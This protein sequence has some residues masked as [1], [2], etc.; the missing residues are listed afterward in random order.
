MIVSPGTDLTCPRCNALLESET[1][2]GGGTI[3]QSPE[4][5]WDARGYLRVYVPG[6]NESNPPKQPSS[7][8]EQAIGNGRWLLELKC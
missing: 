4:R 1:I 2:A 6:A 5:R 3:E 7:L 8:P